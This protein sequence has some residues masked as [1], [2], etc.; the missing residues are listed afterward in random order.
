[1]GSFATTVGKVRGLTA[2]AAPARWPELADESPAVVCYLDGSVLKAPPGG[3]PY[4][5]AVIAVAGEQAEL[6][7]AGYRDQIPVRA[8]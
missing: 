4:E 6:I 8:P 3:D 7:I 2:G 5:R 1:M